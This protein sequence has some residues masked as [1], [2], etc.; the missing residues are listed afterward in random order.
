MLT[1]LGTETFGLVQTGGR[2]TRPCSVLPFT[3]TAT[4]RL[5]ENKHPILSFS[6]LCLQR[7]EISQ[8][9][10]LTLH[11]WVTPS[12][13]LVAQLLQQLQGPSRVREVGCCRAPPQSTAPLQLCSAC[14]C[15]EPPSDGASWAAMWHLVRTVPGEQTQGGMLWGRLEVTP[16]M[17]AS[18]MPVSGFWQKFV[19]GQRWF[20]TQSSRCWG[21]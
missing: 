2:A 18:P 11:L 4:S 10:S 3:A 16:L 19:L 20:C 13:E 1:L 7:N 12:S 15:P 5:S 8:Q 6:P 21:Y 17:S 14:P 9:N